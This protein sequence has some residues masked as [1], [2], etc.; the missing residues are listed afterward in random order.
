MMFEVKK[1]DTLARTGIF[2]HDGRTLLT[3]DVIDAAELF[4]ALADSC[5]DNV[6]LPADPEF[7]DRYLP[8]RN[9]PTVVHPAIPATAESGFAVMVP[10]WH[11]A[12]ENPR[13]YVRWLVGLKER[14]PPD[15]AWFTP[16]SALPSRVHILCYSGFDLFDFTAVDLASAKN[17]FCTPE[18]EFPAEMMDSGVCNCEGCRSRD[19]RMHNR[20]SLVT[21]VRLVSWFVAASRLRELVEARCR[22]HSAHVAILRHLDNHYQFMERNAPA[23]RSVPLGATTGEVLRRAEVIRFADRVCN[24]YRPPKGETVVLLPCSAKK[25]YSLSRSHSQLKAA[26]GGR[27]VELIVTSPLG[28]VPRE[29]EMVYPAAHYDVP[30]TGYWDREELSFAADVLYRYLIKNP[31]GRV[32]AHLEGGALESARMAADSAGVA[33]EVTCTRHPLAAESL[34]ALDEALAG[35]RKVA[36]N[37]FRGTA[38]WQFGCGIDC[39]ALQVRG[40]YPRLMASVNRRPYFSIDTG[41]G[42]LRPTLEGWN[43]IPGVYRVTMADFDLKGDILAPGVTNADPQIR[44]GDEVLV[45]GPALRATGKAMMS[46][47]EMLGSKRGVAVRVRKIKRG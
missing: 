8:R 29:L 12:F 20:L 27:A 46:A 40:R 7:V 1:R 16:G 9:D 21:E 4:P 41:T 3:P 28:L 14:L 11:T 17:L 43:L 25:P 36:H 19:L 37:I 30:V 45:E 32:L 33:L 24:R 38:S 10:C 39:S 23:A 18:G 47:H 22:L 44:P 2:T 35:E 42:L 26:V 31:P 13:N 15:T 34:A 5:C 6:P